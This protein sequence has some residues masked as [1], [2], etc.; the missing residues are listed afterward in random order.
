VL[1]P[2]PP[3]YPSRPSW[4]E[5]KYELVPCSNMATVHHAL[6]RMPYYPDKGKFRVNEDLSMNMYCVLTSLV[7]I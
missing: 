6:R 5:W 2:N 1:L 3:Q 7:V 4:T